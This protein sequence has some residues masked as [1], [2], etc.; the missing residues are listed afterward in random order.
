MREEH[1]YPR[2]NGTA[3][4]C[5]LAAAFFFLSSSP[6]AAQNATT[7]G[8]LALASTFDCVSVRASFTGDVNATNR[9]TIAY[10]A[11][12]SSTWLD[13]YPPV[14]DRRATISGSANPY[15]NQF[16]GS[17][18]G[19]RAGTSYEVRLAFVDTDGVSGGPTLVGTVVTLESTPPLGGRT[20]YVDDVT[21]D[22]DGSSASP[23]NT[24]AKGIA[25]ALPGD[26][27]YIRTG[28][29]PPFTISK[30]GTEG[31]WLALVGESRDATFI[32]GGSVT[33]NVTLSANYVQVKNLRLKQ[34]LHNSV[35]VS[36]DAHH[37]W[38]DNLYHE[39][40]STNPTTAS[41]YSDAGVLVAD[42]THHV[43]VLNSQFYSAA[44]DS[45]V[46]NTPNN[47][48]APVAGVYVGAMAPE[49]T[50][51]IKN[52]T[53]S[54]RFRDAIGNSPEAFGYGARDNSDIANN[55]ITNHVDDGIQ[56]EGDDTN[57]RIWGN[58]I[59]TLGS[60]NSGIAQQSSYVG[61]VYV[62]RNVLIGGT[63]F[64]IGGAVFTFY[65]H[66][67]IDLTESSGDAFA[68]GNNIGQVLRNNIIKTQRNSLYE[69]GNAGTG[70]SDYNLHYRTSRGYIVY[71]WNGSENYETLT[72]ATG[73][74]A[75][76]QETH[77]VQGDPL[78]TGAKKHIDGQSPAYNAGVVIPNFND[79]AS[80]WPYLGAAP[81]MGAHEVGREPLAPANVVI[82]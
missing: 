57:L 14:A 80:A 38:L 5:L 4:A 15:V 53:F 79:A 82:R 50:L 74:Q 63:G 25:A 21:V 29:Y 1:S 47:W 16:R 12:G 60:G 46:N 31:A 49:G 35:Y 11:A 65:F 27:V 56:M 59:T 3:L 9:A 66:N 32:A 22:G 55:T 10:R 43:Y 68:G 62:F 40:I 24:I 18:V 45:G 17:I 19:L 37:V 44:A 42:G 33:N 28:T 8:T 76:G 61:P 26:T 13:A 67:T 54:A 52:N 34:T 58:F 71:G 51:I 23:F 81:D 77:G 2:R 39:N 6:L 36:Q 69:L 41:N 72:G 64:K 78:F 7:V 70:S 75:A 20:W 73:F 30:S 48:D